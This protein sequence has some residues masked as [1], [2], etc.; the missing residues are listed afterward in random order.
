M[1]NA[2]WNVKNIIF[3][4]DKELLYEKNYYQIYIYFKKWNVRMYYKNYFIDA[5]NETN[6]TYFLN[7]SN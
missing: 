1:K 5:I 3:V 4:N 6:H 2:V 7:Y